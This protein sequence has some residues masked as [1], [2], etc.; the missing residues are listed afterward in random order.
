[1]L[2]PSKNYVVLPFS[3][4][5]SVLEGATGNMLD[6]GMVS[7]VT[8]SHFTKYQNRKYL[9]GAPAM[10][11]IVMRPQIGK[12]YTFGKLARLEETAFMCCCFAV[13]S[14]WE[15]SKQRQNRLLYFI[16]FPG[17]CILP[18]LEFLRSS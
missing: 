1:M 4:K 17:S 10:L 6:K 8:A 13:D 16:R 9:S 14:P 5:A 18:E 12:Q 7:S 11:I 15:E 2:L 3:A